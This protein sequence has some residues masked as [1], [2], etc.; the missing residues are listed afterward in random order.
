MIPIDLK[1]FHKANTPLTKWL[2][3]ATLEVL[4]PAGKGVVKE[5][6]GLGLIQEDRCRMYTG[7]DKLV[8]INAAGE[9]H[10]PRDN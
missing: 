5:A 9:A 1:V 6:G 7:M 2:D 8:H 3:T 4:V 10:E